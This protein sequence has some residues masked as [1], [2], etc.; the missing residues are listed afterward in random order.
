[1]SIFDRKL[2]FEED[3]FLELFEK[4]VYTG[5]FPWKKGPGSELPFLEDHYASQYGR[6]VLREPNGWR[7][8][9]FDFKGTKGYKRY[10]KLYAILAHKYHKSKYSNT[11]QEM[12]KSVERG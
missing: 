5:K 3:E 8:E 7:K 10:R 6:I 12:R 9:L 2:T 4:V 11:F 1:M